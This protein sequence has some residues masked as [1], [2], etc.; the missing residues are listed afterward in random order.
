MRRPLALRYSRRTTC[1]H[2]LKL[3]KHAPE[4]SLLLRLNQSLP[5]A[6]FNRPGLSSREALMI[7]RGLGTFDIAGAD[8]VEV[9][10][11]YDHADIIS[12]AGAA[13]LQHSLGLL[14]ER[15]AQ[16]QAKTTTAR[17]LA[18]SS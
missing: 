17:V 6:L 1:P 2:G 9:A 16:K 8:V 18:T 12:I 5:N 11:A 7:L 15:K 4:T 10:T 3:E 14:A 13:V